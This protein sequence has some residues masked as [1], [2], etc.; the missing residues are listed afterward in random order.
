MARQARLLFA[1]S[2]EE[3]SGETMLVSDDGIP[4]GWIFM[5]GGRNYWEPDDH[6]VDRGGTAAER[7]PFRTPLEVAEARVEQVMTALKGRNPVWPY[8]ASLEVL[9]R[10][11][12]ARG[13]T[14]F[15]KLEA[16]W[17]T[18]K[19]KRRDSLQQAVSYGENYVNAVDAADLARLM[20][21]VATLEE[22]APFV[23]HGDAGDHK[24]FAKA[25]AAE[26]GARKAAILAVGI[27]PADQPR[28]RE[29]YFTSVDAKCRAPFDELSEITLLDGIKNPEAQGLGAKLRKL[30]KRG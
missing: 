17:A 3:K 6:V 24:R 27:P 5:F 29:R 4:F 7:D 22:F 20:P 10:R 8:L 9:H 26:S 28:D 21:L 25:R 12:I 16:P 11:I 14:G 1:K 13:K 23:P 15:L 2:I 30:L 19:D 18:T